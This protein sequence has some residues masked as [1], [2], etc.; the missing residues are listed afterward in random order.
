MADYVGDDDD[1]AGDDNSG[2]DEI[3]GAVGKG[4]KRALTYLAM[5][6]PYR[7][8]HSFRTRLSAAPREPAS[9]HRA[10]SRSR[11]ASRR[12]WSFLLFDRLRRTGTIAFRRQRQP[13]FATSG[14]ALVL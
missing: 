11:F 1:N 9:C 12:S 14:T 6:L 2:D 8:V 13:T 5:Y 7:L 10:S 3:L 4:R